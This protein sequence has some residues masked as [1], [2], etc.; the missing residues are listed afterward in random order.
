MA[1]EQ[2]IWVQTDEAEDVAGSLR[3]ALHCADYVS[4]DAQAWKWVA[5]AL[6]SALQGACVCHLTTS[7]APV[8]AVTPRNAAEWISFAE[9]SR[10]DPAATPPRT[11]L[12]VLPDLLKAVRKPKSAGDRGNDVGIRISD[13]E[14]VWLKKFH[15]TVRNQFVHFEPMGWSLEVSGIPQIGALVARIINDILKLGYGFRHCNE[16]WVEA[17]AADLS[18]LSEPN[19]IAPYL[20]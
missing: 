14:F 9:Q 2:E 3:H 6:H 5:L 19:W 7:F 10:T 13:A 8:G 15:D 20:D 18:R 1:D 4:D 17:V 11:Q 12:M 16:K